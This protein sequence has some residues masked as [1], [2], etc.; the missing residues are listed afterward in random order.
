VIPL[1]DD[2]WKQL[3]TAYGDGTA[4]AKALQE[5]KDATIDNPT[6][7]EDLFLTRIWGHVCHQGTPYSALF[8]AI[9]HLVDIAETLDPSTHA[10]ATI[11]G[12]LGWG[13]VNAK[14]NVKSAGDIGDLDPA[15]F[16]CRDALRRAAPLI[17]ETILYDHEDSITAHLF[18]A[19]A[20]IKGNADLYFAMWGLFD[21]IKR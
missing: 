2:T 19:L 6:A 13:A 14:M 7:I 16:D 21:N 9:P 4:V 11:L 8:A 17:A 10:R 3:G 15:R 5:A 12:A 18:A 1:S 20:A